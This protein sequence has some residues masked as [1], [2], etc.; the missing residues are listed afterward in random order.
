MGTGLLMALKPSA[1]T[2]E[3]FVDVAGVEK[4]H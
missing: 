4:W 2:I 3:A 1:S